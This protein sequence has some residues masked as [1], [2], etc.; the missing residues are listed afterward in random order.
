MNS[1]ALAR[2][3]ECVHDCAQR[4]DGARLPV[5]SSASLRGGMRTARVYALCAP[6][7][8]VHDVLGTP[9]FPEPSLFVLEANCD[10]YRDPEVD[11]DTLLVSPLELAPVRGKVAWRVY[12]YPHG[13]PSTSLP[14]LD[15]LQAIA[16]YRGLL[17]T[18]FLLLESERGLLRLDVPARPSRFVR[19]DTTLTLFH[20]SS[21]ARS[22]PLAPT[23]P[24]P[25]LLHLPTARARGTG[26]KA[27]P[28]HTSMRSS[29][30][31]I[32]KT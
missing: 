8:L 17:V 6:A 16:G 1:T 28:E 13:L 10:A 29:A 9:P 15:P 19:G 4:P 12:E 20:R 32:A 23:P 25:A 21:H 11:R 2:R 3:E 7:Q 30:G 26:G 5:A 24:R 27:F 31:A 22:P 14:A 18:A